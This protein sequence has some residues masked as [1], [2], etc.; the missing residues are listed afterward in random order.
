MIGALSGGEGLGSA[1]SAYFAQPTQNVNGLTAASSLTGGEGGG[2]VAKSSA[3]ISGPGQLLS[4]LQQLQAQNPTNFQQVVSQI[5]SQL[6]AA[7]QQAQGPQSD[8]LSNLAAKF[9]SVA[10]GGSLSQLQP[11]QHPHPNHQAFSQGTPN[12]A[13]GVAGLAQPSASQS[14]NSSTLQQLFTTISTEVSQALTS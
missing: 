9:Q 6:Q 7:A 2:G 11:Q 14:S 12:Q 13:Q 8:F 4:N 10:G 5:A 3:T 1:S